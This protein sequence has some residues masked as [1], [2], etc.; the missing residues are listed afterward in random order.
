[1]IIRAFHPTVLGT[2]QGAQGNGFDRFIQANMDCIRMEPGRVEKDFQI[3]FAGLRRVECVKIA[4]K[5][6]LEL[7][8]NS[9]GEEIKARMETWFLEGKF[10][11]PEP[12]KNID[13]AERAEME[14]AMEKRVEERVM[15]KMGLG[16]EPYVPPDVPLAAPTN[17]VPEL[18]H[19]SWGQLKKEAARLDV[20]HVSL[21]R[22]ELEERVMEARQRAAA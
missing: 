4:R 22:P 8:E 10:P 5:H 13:P 21:K 7:D 18:A 1:M 20:F 16:P 15:R 3:G 17:P 12:A 2:G 11:I 6:G 19:L 9:P 14:A